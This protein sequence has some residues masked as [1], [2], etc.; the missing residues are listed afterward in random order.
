MVLRS[1]LKEM[2]C[3][4]V[5]NMV[6]IKSSNYDLLNRTVTFQKGGDWFFGEAKGQITKIERRVSTP[7]LFSTDYYRGITNLFLAGGQ[8]L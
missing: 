5:V 2:K 7:D 3:L 6:P 8:C 1:L 4:P